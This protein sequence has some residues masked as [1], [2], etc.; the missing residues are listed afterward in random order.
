MLPLTGLPMTGSGPGDGAR[1]P[2]ASPQQAEGAGPKLSERSQLEAEVRWK[3][4]LEQYGDRFSE[5]QKADLRRLSI[6]VQPSLDRVRAYA[7]GNETLPAV[8]LKPLVDRD[9]KPVA[10]AVAAPKSGKP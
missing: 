2:A 1:T 6:F 3:A 7:V 9:K 5:A 8:Y 10:G 4:I